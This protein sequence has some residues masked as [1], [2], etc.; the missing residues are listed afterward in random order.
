MPCWSF[1]GNK[2]PQAKRTPFQRGSSSLHQELPL[3]EDLLLKAWIDGTA[4]NPVFTDC[5]PP[6]DTN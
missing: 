3:E 4:G 1:G 6:G 2:T 5:I